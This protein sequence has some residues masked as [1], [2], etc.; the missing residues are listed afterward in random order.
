MSN[1]I[2]RFFDGLYIAACFASLRSILMVELL[3]LEN[4][5]NAFGLCL[6]FTGVSATVGGPLASTFNVLFIFI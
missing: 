3:G 1:H 4:L 5:T 6:M 2:I